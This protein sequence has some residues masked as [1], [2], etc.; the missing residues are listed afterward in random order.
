M[1]DTPTF[2]IDLEGIHETLEAMSVYVRSPS[3]SGILS[4]TPSTSTG[5]LT[6]ASNDKMVSSN[7]SSLPPG[8]GGV[9][10]SPPP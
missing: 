7:T 3:G 2:I 4:A 1:I 6:A 8:L 10:F 9:H 5:T